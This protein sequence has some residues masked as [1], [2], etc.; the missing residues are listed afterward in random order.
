[1]NCR[2]T[3]FAESSNPEACFLEEPA[4]P[5]SELP[6]LKVPFASVAQMKKK[7]AQFELRQANGSVVDMTLRRTPRRRVRVLAPRVAE[8]HVRDRLLNS[9]SERIFAEAG[10]VP[11]FV[12]ACTSSR[13]RA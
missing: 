6:I 2:G 1:M 7:S 5:I 10:F 8:R 3:F 9:I 13:R 4:K 11:L 12:G